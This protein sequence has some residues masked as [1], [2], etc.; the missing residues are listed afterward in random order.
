ME[1]IP[2]DTVANWTE[3]A[4]F[5]TLV[6]PAELTAFVY[7]PFSMYPNTYYQQGTNNFRAKFNPEVLTGV[8]GDMPIPMPSSLSEYLPFVGR[9]EAVYANHQGVNTWDVI[10]NPDG[11]RFTDSLDYMVALDIDQAHAPWLTATGN[12]SA[13]V[14][15]QDYITL[16]GANSMMEAF[17]PYTGGVEEAEVEHW[18]TTSARCSISALPGCGTISPRLDDDFQSEGPDFPA[19]ISS[20]RAIRN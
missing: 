17:G 15:F 13:N 2:A 11:V 7:D 6:G 9:A 19:L 10:G 16:D 3:G 5:H 8:T 1:K 14:E 18:R 12:V 20:I 4:R